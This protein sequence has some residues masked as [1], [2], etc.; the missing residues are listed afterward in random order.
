MFRIHFVGKVLEV[1][2]QV[3]VTPEDV[4]ITNATP[5]PVGAKKVRVSIML[6]EMVEAHVY[7]SISLSTADFRAWKGRNVVIDGVE[8]SS[9]LKKGHD[10][11]FRMIGVMDY[12]NPIAYKM[13]YNTDTNFRAA[14]EQF[15]DE[16]LTYPSSR[17]RTPSLDRSRSPA[18]R[19]SRRSANW[20]RA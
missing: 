2:D 11:S 16:N 8:S 18:G 3:L 6:K 9:T 7:N 10:L 1:G 14:G 4:T 5:S 13:P 20:P 17:S 19:G 15:T 12:G